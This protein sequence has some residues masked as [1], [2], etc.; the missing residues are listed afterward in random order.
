[1]NSVGP[2]TTLRERLSILAATPASNRAIA[3][4]VAGVLGV[5]MIVALLL[6]F[7]PGPAPP[8][9]APV[10]AP[11]PRVQAPPTPAPPPQL[12][13][14][15]RSEARRAARRFIRAYVEYEYGRLDA[16]RLPAADPRLRSALA[17]A[18]PRVTTDASRRHPHVDRVTVVGPAPDMMSFLAAVSDDST[19]RVTAKPDGRGRWRV[20]TVG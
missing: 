12:T 18:P 16:H 17:K 3:L 2:L 19:I 7:A 13:S 1:M 10:A 5:A 11:P 20:V 4:I 8:M 14:A 15:D 6:A 9:P